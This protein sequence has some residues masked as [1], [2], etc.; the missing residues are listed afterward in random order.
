MLHRSLERTVREGLLQTA[1]YMDQCA[2]QA[3]H[4]VIFDRGADKR[5]EDKIFGR[6]EH[7]DDRHRITVWG[8]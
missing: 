5:W 2:A 8:M 3:G 1:E 4:L 7:A 6:D